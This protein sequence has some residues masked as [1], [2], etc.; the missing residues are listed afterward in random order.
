[1]ANDRHARQNEEP[2]RV[3][4]QPIWDLGPH[5]RQDEEPQRVMGYPVDSVGPKLALPTASGF[6]R[7]SIPSGRTGDGY[8]A[9]GW[10]P[11]ATDEDE[12]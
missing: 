8:A 3:L 11:H 10:V 7:W 9:A 4:G 2:Q 12:P 5:A 6:F 1:M